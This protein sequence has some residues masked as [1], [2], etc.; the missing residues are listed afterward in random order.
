MLRYKGQSLCN[1]FACIF[2]EQRQ[3]GKFLRG[4]ALSI[5]KSKKY[6]MGNPNKALWLSNKA[7]KVK[8]N[9][10]KT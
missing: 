5:D 1:L 10:I 4:F 6:E 2:F 9:F 7:T 8:Y 3:R